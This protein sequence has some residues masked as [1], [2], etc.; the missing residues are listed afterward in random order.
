MYADLSWY[1]VAVDQA[2][3]LQ[4]NLMPRGEE[5]V[6]LKTHLKRLTVYCSSVSGKSVRELMLRVY[7][8]H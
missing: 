6:G 4:C 3:I 7:A 2:L 8:S 5:S 1:L